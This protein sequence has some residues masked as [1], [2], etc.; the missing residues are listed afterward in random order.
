MTFKKGAYCRYDAGV[1]VENAVGGLRIFLP[2]ERGYINYNLVHSVVPERNCD[3]WRLGVAY[4]TD[5]NFGNEF[6]LTPPGAEWDMAI[7]IKDRPDFIGGFAHGDEIYDTLSVKIDGNVADI[8]SLSELT[9][10]SEL[11]IGISSFGFDP[12][13]SK[14]QALRHFKEF[15]INEGGVSL[16]QRVEWLNNY[17]LATSY[18]AMMPPLKTLTESFYT[19]AD[20]EPKAARENYD[21]PISGASRAVVF[22]AESGISYTM[23]VK[24]PHLVGGDR[25]LLSDNSRGLYNKM[26][27]VICNGAEVS[28]G[29][30]IETLT[31]YVIEK[32]K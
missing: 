27:F 22:G 23:S 26:Y 9:P 18:M 10:F 8:E 29:N 20:T 24:F 25:F 17:T 21:K 32:T 12:L 4:A 28:K 1:K 2:A 16:N 31:K 3:T 14:T 13:D 19:D 7:R 11:V 30:V 6:P 15:S 5:E